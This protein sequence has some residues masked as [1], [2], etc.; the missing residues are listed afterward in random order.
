MEV[1]WLFGEDRD[2][3]IAQLLLGLFD[4]DDEA[5]CAV[6]TAAGI[7]DQACSA[8]IQALARLVWEGRASRERLLALLDR[9]D[10]EALVP[11][12][13]WAWFG[14]QEAVQLLG[15]TDWIERVQRGWEAGRLSVSFGDVD[16]QDWIERTR[17]PRSIRTIPKRFADDL[18]VPLDD[19]VKDVGWSA[20]PAGGPGDPL[21]G[22][23]SRGWMW[24]FGGASLRITN[25]VPGVGR[26]VPDRARRWSGAHCRLR[27]ICRRSSE[28]ARQAHCS[29]RQSTMLTSPSCWPES[30]RSARECLRDDD[31][32]EPWITGDIA[33]LRGALW[34]QGYLAGI[35]KRKARLAA[36]DRPTT[37]GRA[38]DRARGR[39]AARSG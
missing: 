17:R 16:R 2:T 6:T 37:T 27:N 5:V 32:L 39:A 13:S 35:E 24:R 38:P 11:I 3:D 7:D 10:R 31:E 29:I 4:G 15:L 9:F 25:E 12:D 1:T 33:E 34:A 30:S 26:R 14:W 8:L 20:D 21:S 28:V 18:L 22:D 36:A 19:P 23:E